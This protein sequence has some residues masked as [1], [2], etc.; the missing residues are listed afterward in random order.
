MA[1]PTPAQ[2]WN[3]FVQSCSALDFKIATREDLGNIVSTTL[4][5]EYRLAGDD[6]PP[7]PVE[8]KTR[9]DR[10]VE[11]RKY[12]E[13]HTSQLAS[14]KNSVIGVLGE[15]MGLEKRYGVGKDYCTT[16][17]ASFL[18]AVPYLLNESE[19]GGAEHGADQ[20]QIYSLD[21]I[22]RAAKT[23]ISDFENSF[24]SCHSYPTDRIAS[25]QDKVAAEWVQSFG[26]KR[27]TG[28]DQKGPFGLK[29][30]EVTGLSGHFYRFTLF[31]TKL[32]ERHEQYERRRS[33]RLRSELLSLA[34][35]ALVNGGVYLS[36]QGYTGEDLGD[37]AADA[38][39]RELPESNITRV[40][41]AKTDAPKKGKRLGY[42]APALEGETLIPGN[43]CDECPRNLQREYFTRLVR[44]DNGAS[45]ENIQTIID[46]FRAG[47][48]SDYVIKD[49][50]ALVELMFGPKENYELPI[51]QKSYENVSKTIRD[52][53]DSGKIHLYTEGRKQNPGTLILQPAPKRSSPG[54]K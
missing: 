8:I 6:V 2:R 12:F 43:G 54:G 21:L 4:Q 36:S 1:K 47:L 28:P 49:G 3:D 32:K 14:E 38:V 44:V 34:L 30:L 52:L 50:A 26:L 35:V 25:E 23:E 45:E 24:V 18:E 5:L 27:H 17:A 41:A 10:F 9:T 33:G 22:L 29:A 51:F 15:I 40:E 19:F 20:V 48:T 7:N 11:A 53:V 46:D 31:D 42:V 39:Y 16:V 37:M 13:N